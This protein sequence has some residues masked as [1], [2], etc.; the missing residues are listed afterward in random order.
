MNV[1]TD[2]LKAAEV[3]EG[4]VTINWT[5]G[6]IG[7]DRSPADYCALFLKLCDNPESVEIGGP[8]CKY[9]ED[10]TVAPNQ[11]FDIRDRDAS[12]LP[13]WR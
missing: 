5:M 13:R 11:C 10:T 4:A 6:A 1:H 8:G 9:Y 12:S 3:S 7:D 2:P